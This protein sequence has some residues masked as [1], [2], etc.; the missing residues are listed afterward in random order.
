M[1]ADGQA[2]CSVHLLWDGG[3][4]S[5]VAQLAAAVDRAGGGVSGRLVVLGGIGRWQ[6]AH[7]EDSGFA[8]SG[9]SGGGGG[10]IVLNCLDGVC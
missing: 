2:V 10:R 6:G 7:G 3:A 9:R 5:M 8:F 4:S 1:S